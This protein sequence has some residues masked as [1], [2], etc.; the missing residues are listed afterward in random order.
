MAWLSHC[1]LTALAC[2]SSFAFLLLSYSS[3][4]PSDY[5]H[6]FLPFSFSFDYDFSLMHITPLA[7]PSRIGTGE[8]PLIVNNARFPKFFSGLS[9]TKS[10]SCSLSLM[11]TL[12]TLIFSLLRKEDMK[13]EASSPSLFSHSSIVVFIMILKSLCERIVTSKSLLKAPPRHFKL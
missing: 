12:T 10:H 8:M 9:S 5:R 6:F 3:S 4:S 13:Q 1:M 11:A 2:S 7:S